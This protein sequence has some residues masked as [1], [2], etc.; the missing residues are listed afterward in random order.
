MRLFTFSAFLLASCAAFEAAAIPSYLHLD[1]VLASLQQRGLPNAPDGYTPKA[2]T[3]PSNRPSIRSAD[4]LSTNETSWLELRRNA[5]VEPMRNLLN[6]MN[7]T[8]F[9]A[10]S[11]INN[12]ADNASA[13]PNIGIAVSGGG[14][15]ALMNA[16]GAV[17]AFDN[18]T[19][20]STSTGQLG[21]LLQSSTYLSGL[22][23]GGWL[24]GSLSIN[25]FSSVTDLL[26]ETSGNVW[27][28]SNSI[29]QGP[30]SGI[31]SEASY[32]TQLYDLVSGKA[33]AGFETSLTDYWGRALSYQ[34]I[35][36]S[37]GGPGYTWSS[38]AL[39]SQFTSGSVPMPILV[40]DGR[41][42]DQL[43]IS[44]NTTV[45]EFNPWE[46]GTFDPSVYGFAPVEYLG[47]NFSAGQVPSNG[48]C[49]RGFDNA[50]FI[51][52]TSSSLFNQFFL[53]LN[54]TSLPSVLKSAFS[55]IL[56]DLG[57]DNDD[58]ADYTPNPFY[59][60]HNDSNP[61]ASS[62]R[63]TLV[64]GGE[65]LQNIPL[66]PLIQPF[67]NVDVILAVDSSA[68]TTTYW[69]NGTALVA[70]YERSLL[71]SSIS[72]GTSF[73]AVPDQNTFVNKG[74]NTRPTF[75][76]CNSS[77]T[78]TMTPLVVY[79]PNTP[80]VFHSNYS[81]YTFTYTDAVRWDIIQNGAAVVTRG[82]AS[83]DSEWP[84]CLGCAIISRSLERNN[85]NVPDICTTCF[86]RYCWDGS[87]NSTTPSGSFEPEY[88]VSA[89]NTTSGAEK[90]IL[91]MGASY[92]SWSVLLAVIA[93]VMIQAVS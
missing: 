31:I 44:S 27:E 15:R 56:G 49:V 85:V 58:I 46:F 91:G 20:N 28:F 45:F 48:K 80:Y 64:D 3:C 22:S 51:M 70:T 72:N 63:L 89:L 14:W 76:G 83:V 59:H 84:A 39:D 1:G 2:V 11:Y 35:N 79:L 33:D 37:E 75:F 23:G 53:S 60:Y 81:T 86:E 25:N 74:L 42:P 54:S 40:A 61:S 24:V 5:T 43:I 9:D 55:A 38:I 29:F 62:K 32:Y 66:H 18:Q 12:H 77:N 67:R 7:I 78:S 87:V 21:G 57:E 92:T 47:S 16:A 68:D 88:V 71:N 93:I 73:P 30:S 41:A 8:G 50:G 69:P 13:L 82:N 6:R 10:T 26:D 4:G 52:G 90:G 34:L 17:K 36:A 65:D 19:S